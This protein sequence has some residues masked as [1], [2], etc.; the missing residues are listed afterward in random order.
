LLAGQP[1]MALPS[2][3]RGAASCAIF[4]TAATH[5]AYPVWWMRAHEMLGEALEQ[6]GDKSGACEAYGVV[7]DRWKNPKPRSVTV[8]KARERVKTLACGR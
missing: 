1:Q 3:R 7:L 5:R 8:E 4:P 6:T 2:L